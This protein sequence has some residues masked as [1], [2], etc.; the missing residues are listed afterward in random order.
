MR[1]WLVLGRGFSKGLWLFESFAANYL[2]AAGEVVQNTVESI[3]DNQGQ[4]G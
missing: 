2:S 3:A 4:R 1:L